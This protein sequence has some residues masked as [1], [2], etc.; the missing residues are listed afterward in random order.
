MDFYNKLLINNISVS[1]AK[2][3]NPLQLAFVG[4]SVFALFI[5]T[6]RVSYINFK[7]NDL[8]KQ[9]KEYVNAKAQANFFFQIKDILTEDE[10]WVAMR[11]RNTNMHSK[12]KNYSIEEYRYATALE[13]VIGFLYVTN[14]I[15]RLN[16]VLSLIK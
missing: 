14:Q 10:L 16:S 6:N 11:A 15:E 8:T 1:Q 9:T 12:A 4:D 13:A 7:V 5:K 3:L 2:Q